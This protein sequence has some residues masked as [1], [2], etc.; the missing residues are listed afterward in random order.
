[1]NKKRVLFLCTGNSARSQMSE[2]MVNHYLGGSWEAVSAGTRPS[3]Y[4]HPLAVRAMAELGMDI[5]GHRSKHT[6]EFRAVEFDLVVTLC[7]DAA[8]NCPAWLGKGRVVHMG[9]PDP[10]GATGSE[11]EQLQVFRRVRDNIRQRVLDYLQQELTRTHDR[12]LEVH[13]ATGDL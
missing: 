3:G 7:D 5:T 10:A 9:F 2:G 13:L 6:D 11:A 8:R 4:V 1:M 12:R